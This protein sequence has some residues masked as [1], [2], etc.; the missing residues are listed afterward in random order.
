MQFLAFSFF[1]S[2]LKY[3]CTIKTITPKNG[4]FKM[5]KP[6]ILEL[7][8]Y[9]TVKRREKHSRRLKD[10]REKLSLI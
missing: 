2:N 5:N 6:E 4:L 1:L 10:V 9:S 3:F 7:S 8:R